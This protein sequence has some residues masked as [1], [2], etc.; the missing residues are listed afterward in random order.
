M[1]TATRFRAGN[2]TSVT[3][4]PSG[5]L[6]RPYIN[7]KNDSDEHSTSK[8][9]TDVLYP[10]TIIIYD[11]IEYTKDRTKQNK[12]KLNKLSNFGNYTLYFWESG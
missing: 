5:K 8:E 1:S 4:Q 6:Y 2:E 12:S 7:D 3:F 10:R 11:I 9:A